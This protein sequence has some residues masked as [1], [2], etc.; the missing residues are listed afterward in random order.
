MGLKS[1]FGR[2]KHTYYRKVFNDLKHPISRNHENS[3]LEETTVK[4]TRFYANIR[5]PAGFVFK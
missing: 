3:I 5:A 4:D 2:E 1:N